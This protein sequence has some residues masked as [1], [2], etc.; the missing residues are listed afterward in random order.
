MPTIDRFI[1]CNY[2]QSYQ[3]CSLGYVNVNVMHTLVQFSGA[4]NIK[5]PFE[6]V[7]LPCPI[8]PEAAPVPANDG[9]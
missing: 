2:W 5:A 6:K 8:R 4:A 1:S 3:L 9:P 7:F